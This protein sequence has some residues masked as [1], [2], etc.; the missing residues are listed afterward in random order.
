[1]RSTF[2]SRMEIMAKMMD[3]IPGMET[4]RPL[5]AF[6]MLPNISAFFGKSSR[7]TTV[8]SADDMAEYLLAEAHVASVSGAAFGAPECVR[9]SYAAAESELVEA[10]KRVKTALEK[11]K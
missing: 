5:G 8:N 3:D 11:L 2:R 9:F 10:M 6:Y 1:M 4:N 7:E